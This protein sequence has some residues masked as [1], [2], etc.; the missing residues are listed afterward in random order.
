MP[1]LFSTSPM[2]QLDEWS[3]LLWRSM[4]LREC[5]IVSTLWW[6][7]SDLYE[8][9]PV[10]VDFQP[11]SIDTRLMFTYTIRSLV[12]ARLL[13]STSSPLA[14]VPMNAMPSGSSASWL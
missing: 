4:K 2:R 5:R 1:L 13:I 11:P 3:S 7:R 6:W 12:A 8:A 14:V 10:A 9:K